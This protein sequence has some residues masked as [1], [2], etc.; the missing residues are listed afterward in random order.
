MQLIFR[1]TG[2]HF[3]AVISMQWYNNIVLQGTHQRKGPVPFFHFRWAGSLLSSWY[4]FCH[5]GAAL[6][7]CSCTLC[8]PLI[9]P[10]LERFAHSILILM[11]QDTAS[12]ADIIKLQ[13][14]L[15]WCVFCESLR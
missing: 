2:T 12:K 15:F 13:A 1:Q 8:G 10:I 6:N 4:V 14:I 5:K 3:L 9:C 11:M 7:G